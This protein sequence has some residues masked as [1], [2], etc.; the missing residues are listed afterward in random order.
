MPSGVRYSCPYFYLTT[1]LTLT[2]GARIPITQAIRSDMGG[3]KNSAY[4]LQNMIIAIST[5]EAA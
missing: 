1:T 2:I 3:A 5:R 4:D